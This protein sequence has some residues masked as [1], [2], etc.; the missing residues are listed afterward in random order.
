VLRYEGVIYCWRCG[1][2]T[3]EQDAICDDCLDA[4]DIEITLP[5]L[6]RYLGKNDPKP[7]KVIKVVKELKVEDR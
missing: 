1:R 4:L 3:F 2:E 7:K 6:S 5:R